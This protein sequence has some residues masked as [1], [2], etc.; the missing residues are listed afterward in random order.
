MKKKYYSGKK[1]IIKVV[2]A[3]VI[4]LILAVG[5]FIFGKHIDVGEYVEYRQT[6][7]LDY[8]VCFE[9]SNDFY[10]EECLPSTINSYV[11]RYIDQIH[12]DFGHLLS[13]DKNVNSTVNYHISG[14]LVIFDRNNSDHVMNRRSYELLEQQRRVEQDVTAIVIEETLSLNY[15]YFNDF[16]ISYK[17]NANIPA[18]AHLVVTLDI[19]VENH[20]ESVEDGHIITDQISLIIPLDEPTIQLTE[21]IIINDSGRV[22]IYYDYL[23]SNDLLFII[24]ILF[25]V[26]S[27]ILILVITVKLM[28]LSQY[29]P[30]Y[31]RIVNSIK[32]EY[33][34]DITN[35]KTLLDTDLEGK[36]TYLDV[37]SFK[38]LYEQARS[39]TGKQIYWNEKQYTNYDNN[40]YNRV[41][42]FFI[43]ID[44][45]KVVRLIIDERKISKEYKDNSNIQ[46]VYK[47]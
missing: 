37:T 42:W 23:F 43:F 17:Q 33:D 22:F 32:N 35:I 1:Q 45:D 14:E 15:N 6:R 25:F 10:E 21:D 27:F 36:Y 24:S 9:E 47:G 26:V 5:L 11:T 2:I 39:G 31:E 8:T 12:I 18:R 30:I 4:C 29:I 44:D 3:L 34:A 19:E 16:V 7:N 41:T 40:V 46:K 28:R 38:E 20:F 13:W